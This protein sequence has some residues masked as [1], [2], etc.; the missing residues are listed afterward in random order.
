MKLSSSLKLFF[1]ILI[2]MIVSCINQK[3]QEE[4]TVKTLMNEVIDSLY[5]TM[6]EQ[7]LYT[8]DHQ[9]AMSFF[10]DD[11]L[12]I[13]STRHWRFVVNVPVVVSVI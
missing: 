13:L 7:E 4:K 9:Q 2:F 10:S 6:D 11:D 3:E 1:G 5:C 12:E 8:I